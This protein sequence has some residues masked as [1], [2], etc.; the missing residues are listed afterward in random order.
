MFATVFAV[1]TAA[2]V[3]TGFG[4]AT[5]VSSGFLDV[6]T[7]AVAAAEV[8]AAVDADGTWHVVWL[9]FFWHTPAAALLMLMHFSPAAS[10]GSDRWM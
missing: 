4:V 5:V 6:V 2:T 1:A 3:A 10:C 8:L 7:G 9:P